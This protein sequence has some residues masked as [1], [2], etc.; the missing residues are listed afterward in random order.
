MT[1]PSSDVPSAENPMPSDPDDQP[2]EIRIVETAIAYVGNQRVGAGNL[3]V[4]DYELPD[5]TVANGMTAQLFLLA[6]GARVIVGPG[7]V[8]DIGGGRWEV[9]AVEKP[10]AGRHGW[11]EL[12]RRDDSSGEPD[13]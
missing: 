5:G 3:W 10:E 12:R 4:A 8:V 1:D 6:D 11:V 2:R 13:E 7:S 9:T